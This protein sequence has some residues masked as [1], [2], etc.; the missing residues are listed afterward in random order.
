MM[1]LPCIVPSRRIRTGV[2]DHAPVSWLRSDFVRSTPGNIF[3]V[4]SPELRLVVTVHVI[5][6]S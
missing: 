6:I 1:C 5:S 3:R 4:K 2:T